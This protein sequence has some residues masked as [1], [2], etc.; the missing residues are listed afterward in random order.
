MA[1]EKPEY[2]VVVG[3]DEYQKFQFSVARMMLSGWTCQG[4]I[5][6]VAIGNSLPPMMRY[7]QAMVKNVPSEL[8]S[9]I[10]SDGA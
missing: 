6:V 10:V 3:I 5:S 7:F 8:P 1:N 9:P 4:G 2:T